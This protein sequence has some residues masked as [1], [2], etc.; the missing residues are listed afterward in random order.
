MDVL[1][2]ENVFIFVSWFL[3]AFARIV[4]TLKKNYNNQINNNNNNNN[5][6]SK[7]A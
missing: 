5:N 7:W 1:Y 6:P 4:P 3:L 2:V